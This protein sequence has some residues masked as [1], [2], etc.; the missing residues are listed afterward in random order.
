[1]LRAIRACST[2]HRIRM[3]TRSSHLQFSPPFHHLPERYQSTMFNTL[4]F[5]TS[6]LLA[7]SVTASPLWSRN[8]DSS[9]QQLQNICEKSVNKGVTDAWSHEACLFGAG[10]FG[11]RTPVAGLLGYIF[12]SKNSPNFNSA[13]APTALTEPRVPFSVR[14]EQ[15]RS[16]E[17]IGLTF[18]IIK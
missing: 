10:C 7:S 2:T 8:S 16:V 17:E 14:C 9:C 18:D 6:L 11:G 4:F 1:V 15:F 3:A 5:T 13:T 12:A